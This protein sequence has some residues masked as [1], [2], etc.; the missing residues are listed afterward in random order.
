MDSSLMDSSLMDSS[1]MD[2]PPMHT[3]PMDTP[4]MD[5]YQP[6]KYVVGSKKIAVHYIDILSF[7]HEMIPEKSMSDFAI[8]RNCSF[9]HSDFTQCFLSDEELEQVNG[10]KS[11]KKQVEWLAGRFIVK[12]M[13]RELEVF[14][15]NTVDT[16][17]TANPLIIIALDQIR[18]SY[19]AQGAPFLEMHPHINISISHSG[20]YA[21]AALYNIKPASTPASTP[22]SEN[23]SESVSKNS[24]EISTSMNSASMNIGLDIEKVGK[25]PDHY[26]I[27]TAFTEREIQNIILTPR[28][29]FRCWTVKEAFLKYIGK[30]F[31]ESLH[32]VEILDRTLFYGGKPMD[33]TVHSFFFENCYALSLIE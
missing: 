8:R 23:A 22:A 21:A 6:V 5:I 27:K 10:Y 3:L 20:D 24:I 19:R 25:L 29:V 4:S 32:S 9:M 14:Y 2:T 16:T 11:F 7:M 31:N 13:V 33:V 30:G 12:N 18:I 26:F 1:L 17:D 15:A 28:E